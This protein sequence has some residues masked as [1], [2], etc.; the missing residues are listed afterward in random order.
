M[1]K[2]VS[3]TALWKAVVGGVANARGTE[4]QFYRGKFILGAMVTTPDWRR[5]VGRGPEA[6]LAKAARARREKRRR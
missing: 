3:E 4:R 6:D 2:S 5:S 1:P